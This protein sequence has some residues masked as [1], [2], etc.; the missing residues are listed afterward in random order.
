MEL[1]KV[2][3]A[4]DYGDCTGTVEKHSVRAVILQNGRIAM[5]QGSRGE[6]KILGGGVDRGE[7]LTQALAR[8]VREEAGLI[9]RT[10][11]I[12]PIGEILELRRD[13]FEKDKKYICHSYFFFCEIEKEH[14][15]CEMTESEIDKGYHLTWAQ[16]DEIIAA[17]QRIA[18]E[19]WLT[20]DAEF[21]RMLQSGEISQRENVSQP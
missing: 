18:D 10:D 11:T 9:V 5:Q 4:K 1:L 6:Y 17:N 15:A 14:C 12:R 13:R 20:R 7:T 19:P 16:F 8:E 3:A 2:F 21:I